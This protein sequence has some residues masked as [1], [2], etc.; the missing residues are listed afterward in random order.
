MMRRG[1][2]RNTDREC[3]L[4]SLPRRGVCVPY[5]SYPVFRYAGKHAC[6]FL[7]L[8]ALLERQRL[9]AIRGCSEVLSQFSELICH[10]QFRHGIQVHVHGPGRAGR[11]LASFVEGPVWSGPKSI[12]KE[13]MRTFAL[14]A[15]LAWA[16]QG[17][18]N[19][20]DLGRAI[21]TQPGN[22]AVGSG[23]ES[24]IRTKSVSAIHNP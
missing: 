11:K 9:S 13:A 17:A 2:D 10:A 3:Q 22:H 23:G 16:T 4:P 12:K 21:K 20:K 7:S 6:N 1:A 14:V 19:R 15:S 18:P 8:E 5:A 24:A